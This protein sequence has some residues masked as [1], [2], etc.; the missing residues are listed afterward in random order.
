LSYLAA[1]GPVFV[2]KFAI[3][4]RVFAARAARREQIAG[5]AVPATNPLAPAMAGSAHA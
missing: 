5:R 2:A 4:D 3:F 1:S